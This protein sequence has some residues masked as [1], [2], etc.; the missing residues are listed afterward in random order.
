MNNEKYSI[1]ESQYCHQDGFS[2]PF[3]FIVTYQW[4]QQICLSLGKDI[5]NNIR[6]AST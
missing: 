3:C 5:Q 2:L 4:S 1:K 6:A